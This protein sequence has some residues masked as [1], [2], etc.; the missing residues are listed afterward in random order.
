MTRVCWLRRIGCTS[1]SVETKRPIRAGCRTPLNLS[2]AADG[3]VWS[4]DFQT[5]VTKWM[6]ERREQ[7]AELEEKWLGGEIPTGVAASLLNM[8]LTRLLIQIPETNAATSDRR[9]TVL[10]PVVFGGRPQTELRMNQAIGLDI[11][12]ILILQD[13]ELLDLI[14]EVFYRVKLSPRCHAVSAPGAEP[15]TFSSAL[16]RQGWSAGTHSAQPASASGCRP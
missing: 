6:P 15:C 7:S 12:S 2:S 4:V 13:L 1:S 16:P 11:T 3:P 5:L 14:F 8:S 10:V 9:V